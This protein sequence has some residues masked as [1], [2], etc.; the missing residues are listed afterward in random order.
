MKWNWCLAWTFVDTFYQF[1]FDSRKKINEQWF[2]H[3]IFE[4]NLFLRM[5]IKNQ[6]DVNEGINKPQEI[7]LNLFGF[8]SD[9]KVMPPPK[10]APIKKRKSRR[11]HDF[12]SH[13]ASSQ[14]NTPILEEKS[15]ELHSNPVQRRPTSV[16]AS[17]GSTAPQRGND[18]DSDG[19]CG[20]DSAWRGSAQLWDFI[21]IENSNYSLH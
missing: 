11:A 3:S 13:H 12:T 2:C 15:H 19:A 4:K 17:I 10:Y 18:S 5:L 16:N 14:P 6:L 1:D 7:D 21:I 20:F 8:Q 9:H